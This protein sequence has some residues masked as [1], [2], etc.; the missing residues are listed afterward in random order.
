MYLAQVVLCAACRDYMYLSLNNW[1]P[2]G[3]IHMVNVCLYLVLRSCLKRI[4][5]LYA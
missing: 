5:S 1:A 3:A 2:I 4:T